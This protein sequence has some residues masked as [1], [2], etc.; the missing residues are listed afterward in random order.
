M[1]EPKVS[2]V[3]PTY[4]RNEWV[5]EAIQSLLQQTV[6]EIELIIVDDGSDDGSDE[7]LNWFAEKDKRVQLIVNAKNMGAGESRSIG[8][9]AARAPIIAICDSDDLSV[10]DR[11]AKILEWFEKNPSSELVNFPY[12]RVNY[13]NEVNE[14]FPGE[15]FD[16]ERFKKSGEINYFS[17]PTVAV[18]R[19]SILAVP[20][21][22]EENG[23]TDDYQLVSDWIKAG[24]RIDFCSD[25]PLVMHRV[26]PNSIMAKKRGFRPEWAA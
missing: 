20:Y 5:G 15:A 23:C 25:E 21:R 10:I 17:N 3:L 7:L 18:K 12:V 14:H 22:K 2:F 11:A 13:W 8:H 19:E 1:K 6:P 16:I 24:K 4:N 26:L 9:Q